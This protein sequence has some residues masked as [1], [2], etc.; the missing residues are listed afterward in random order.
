MKLIIF[1]RF[2]IADNLAKKALMVASFWAL[3]LGSLVEATPL[4]SIGVTVSDLG[5]PFF[6][7]IGETVESLAKKQPGKIKVSVV[8]SAYDLQRQIHQIDSFISQK[9]DLIVLTADHSE[10][11][12]SATQ[13]ARNAGIKVLAVDVTAK[14]ADA[15]ITTDNLQAGRLACQFLAQK[16]RGK[17]NLVIINGPPVS[18]VR[19][20]VHGCKE[21]LESYS[22][23]I[24]LSDKENGGGSKVGG[25]EKMT[26]SLTIFDN[27]DAVFAINDPTALG[28]EIAARQAGRNGLI[29]AS[30]DGSPA[31]VD[32]LKDPSSLI[33]ASAAQFP[34][35]M[36]ARALEIGIQ[37]LNGKPLANSTVLI[38]A[39]LVT[40]KNVSYYSGWQ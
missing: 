35:Q 3:N 14:K 31:I 29:I 13:R 16:L 27:I 37:L 12:A 25:L 40:K 15:T 26:N 2:L 7:R 8:S 20:R 21:A 9:V 36:A 6:A 28:A 11:I 4:R 32:R 23:I 19:D 1:R 24:I 17:G 38:P 18:S 39:H 22:R 10:R 33:A 30:V 5:N 34:N